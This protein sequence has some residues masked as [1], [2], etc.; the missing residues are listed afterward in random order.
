MSEE[1]RIEYLKEV[2]NHP[3]LSYATHWVIKAIPNP[4]DFGYHFGFFAASGDEVLESLKKPM[5]ITKDVY[6]LD[7]IREKIDE[8]EMMARDVD[9]SRLKENLTRNKLLF[10]IRRRKLFFIP[11]KLKV[12]VNP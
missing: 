6:P 9:I 11:R 10:S 1:D 2:K 12:S 8:I 3:K 7:S 5:F 4:V